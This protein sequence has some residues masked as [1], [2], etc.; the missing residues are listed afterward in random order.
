VVLD[1]TAETSHFNHFIVAHHLP[2]CL[3]TI[4]CLQVPP[5]LRRQPQGGALCGGI[6]DI[7][8]QP[9][10]II[11]NLSSSMYSFTVTFL[12]SAAAHAPL[13][14]RLPASPGFVAPGPQ[15]R[16]VPTQHPARFYMNLSLSSL[17]H[18]RPYGPHWKG[19]LLPSGCAQSH[20]SCRLQVPHPLP[21]LPRT[22]ALPNC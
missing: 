13:P 14:V 20:P 7:Q 4:L 19:F 6:R 5:A 11:S 10:Q 3:H 22:P 18:C 15:Q 16:R 17:H 1:L 8:G 9:H 2:A 12:S 21:T